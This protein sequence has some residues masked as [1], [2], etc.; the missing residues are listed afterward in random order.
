MLAAVTLAP[1]L[2]PVRDRIQSSQIGN[3]GLGLALC[4][5][6]VL[7]HDGVIGIEDAQPKGGLLL[8]R[9]SLRPAPPHLARRLVCPLQ[10]LDAELLHPKQSLHDSFGLRGIGIGQH[11]V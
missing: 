9:H 1:P 4:E 11:L 10:V 7:R 5:K 6:V 3:V 2:R 8:L